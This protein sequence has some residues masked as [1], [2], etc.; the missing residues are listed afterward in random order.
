MK[1]SCKKCKYR[2]RSLYKDPCWACESYES[3]SEY[4]EKA[5]I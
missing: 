2:F 5:W 4:W 1:K 3:R